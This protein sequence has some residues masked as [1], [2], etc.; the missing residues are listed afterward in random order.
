MT[1]HGCL[2]ITEP[3]Q[4]TSVPYLERGNNWCSKTCIVK[5]PVASEGK[6]RIETP[7]DSP[8]RVHPRDWAGR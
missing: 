4:Y 2:G 6:A 5:E 1:L 7:E 8:T 3:L